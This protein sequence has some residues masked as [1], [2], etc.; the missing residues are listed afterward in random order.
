MLCRLSVR[1]IVPTRE[2]QT[3]YV[4]R[5][6]GEHTLG[7]AGALGVDQKAFPSLHEFVDF[8]RNL[9]VSEET[10]LQAEQSTLKPASALR[11]ITFAENEQLAFDRIQD[12]D[13]DPFS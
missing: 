6:A 2:N 9:G 10:I 1:R 12:A 5:V 8:L 11:F 4:L 7:S 3:E 13:L